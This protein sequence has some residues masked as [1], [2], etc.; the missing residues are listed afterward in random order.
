MSDFLALESQVKCPVRGAPREPRR[1]DPLPEELERLLVELEE[2]MLAAAEELRFE[3]AP[4]CA[5]RS[6]SYAASTS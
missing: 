6:R 1:G 3:Y 4:S 5:T 2:E